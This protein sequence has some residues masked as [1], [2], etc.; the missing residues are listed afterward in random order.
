VIQGP[1]LLAGLIAGAAALSFWLEHR[2][3][4]LS[5][6]GAALL[7]LLFGGLLSN[8]GLVPVTSPVYDTIAGPVT[9]LA[10]IWLL[11]AV[12]VRDLRKAGPRMG[13]AFGLAA[14]G[15]AVGA[16]V[17]GLVFSGAFPGD[18]WRLAGTLTGTYTGGSVNF[19]AVARGVDLPDRL[20]AGATAADALTTALWMGVCLVLP[21]LLRRWYPYPIPGEGEFDQGASVLEEGQGAPDPNE[22]HPIHEHHPFFIKAGISTT[23]LAILVA[24]GLGILVASEWIA[25]LLAAPQGLLAPLPDIPAVLWLTTLALAAGHLTPLG[26]VPGSMQLGSVALQLFFVVIGIFSRVSE[27]LVVGIEVFWMTLVIV[28]VHGLAVFGLGR[29]LKIDVGTLSVAAQAAV[30]GPSSAMAV[31]VAREWKGLV[32]PGIAVGLLGYAVGNYLGFAVA[33]LLRGF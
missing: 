12:N 22:P 31:A 2:F 20:F 11:L 15:T 27:I 3:R 9:L 19:V 25:S 30:G 8:T 13:L 26:R 17:A 6:V 10:I 29:L 33:Y 1:L 23:D 7:A 16:V 21:I 14:L 4:T 5:T 28:G 18:G 32:L 24:A